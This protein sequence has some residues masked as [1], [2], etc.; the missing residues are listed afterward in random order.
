MRMTS[1]SCVCMKA[2]MLMAESDIYCY[3]SVQVL[4]VGALPC[5]GTV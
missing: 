2:T 1:G 3:E 4:S 5:G